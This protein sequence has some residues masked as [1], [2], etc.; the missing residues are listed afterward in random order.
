M[1]IFKTYFK[2]IKKL[3]IQLSI[4]IVVFLA[5]S[6]MFSY[7]GSSNDPA[8]FT[9]SKTKVAF[10]NE[11]EDSVLVKGFKDYLEKHS[12]FKQVGSTNEDLQDALFFREVEYIAKIPKGFTE[13]LMAGGAPAISK[14]VVSGNT[15]GIYTDILVNKYFNTARLYIS[16]YKGITQEEL[17]KQVAKDLAIETD[18]GM[19]TNEGGVRGTSPVEYF[20]NYMA[21]VLISILVLGVSSIMLVFND[22]KLRRRNLCSPITNT[23]MN[24]QILLGNVVFSVVCWALLIIV[25]FILYGE[26]MFSVN[27]IYFCLNSLVLTMTI[28]SMSFLIGVLIKSRNAQSGISNVLSLGLCFLSGVFVPQE[29]LGENVLAIARFTPTY[30][31]I[32]ANKA[33]GDLTNYSFEHLTPILQFMLIELGFA[34]ALISITLVMSKRKQL[35]GT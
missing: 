21:Y 33:I 1:T 20:Y 16:S 13:E 27:T 7:M 5:L 4:Y 26:S 8:A 22:T 28:L 12:I 18:V 11:D 35:R 29:F 25:G 30:W 3:S 32:K 2:I 34:A 15:S 23:S 17:V 9:Q 14:T 24:L 10:I 6:I 31:Y 19:K